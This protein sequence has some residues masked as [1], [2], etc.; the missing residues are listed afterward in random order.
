MRHLTVKTA[1]SDSGRYVLAVVE[2]DGSASTLVCSY[3]PNLDSPDCFEDLVREC[4]KLRSGDNNLGRRFQLLY[5][6]VIGPFYYGATS[7]Q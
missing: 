2:I 4:Y 3:G 7:S 5:G 1:S 6:H